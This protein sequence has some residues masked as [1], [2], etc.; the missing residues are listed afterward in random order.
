MSFQEFSQICCTLVF[1]SEPLDEGTI[2]AEQ[3]NL[4]T[5]CSGADQTGV[6]EPLDE[7][8]IMAEQKNLTTSRSGTDQTG[9]GAEI[10]TPQVISQGFR[11]MEESML[12]PG[13][14][15]LV[16]HQM[17]LT[18]TKKMDRMFTQPI[19]NPQL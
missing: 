1:V 18:L 19:H 4:T 2:M 5:S 13:N 8:T 11:S 17:V 9:K 10:L 14:K 15:L 6:S 3:K 12:E 16:L 7:G